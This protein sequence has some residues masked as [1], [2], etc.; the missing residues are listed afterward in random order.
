MNASRLK[1]TIT[2]TTIVFGNSERSLLLFKEEIKKKSITYRGS[3]KVAATKMRLLKSRFFLRT[4]SPAIVEDTTQVVLVDNKWCKA[5]HSRTKS[6]VKVLRK[7]VIFKLQ[8]IYKNT[9][10][11]LFKLFDYTLILE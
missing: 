9:S 6:P 7:L 1:S 8:I 4:I 5:A 3:K 11:F 2:F 10:D